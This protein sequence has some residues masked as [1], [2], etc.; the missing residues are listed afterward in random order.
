MSNA[1]LYARYLRDDVRYA[2]RNSWLNVLAGSG[3]VTR[4]LRLALYRAG[5][6]KVG[7]ANIYPHLRFLGSAT[8]T[9]ADGVMI[10][11][12]V[13]IDNKASVTVGENV[14]IAP[15]VYIGTSTHT[16]ADGSR[17]AG[18][19][20]NLPIVIGRG[21]WIGARAIILPGVTVGEGAVIAAGA[22]VTKDCEADTLYGGVPARALRSYAA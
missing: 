13:T 4:G 8:V 9:I 7:N 19:V 15:E 16:V 20:E 10:N 11:V 21:A 1:R 12:S 22:V 18:A 17:R 14:H 2:V 3:L 6:V 5:G